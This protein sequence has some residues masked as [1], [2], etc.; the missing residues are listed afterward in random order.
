V[1]L[2]ARHVEAAS[3]STLCMGSALDIIK[4]GNPPRAAFLD[5]PLGHTTGKPHQPELQREILVQALEGFTSMT[6]PGSVKILPFRWSEEDEWKHTAMMDGDSRTPRN[7]IPQY[8][9]EE[10]RRRAEENNPEACLVCEISA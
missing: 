10:D 7:E 2:I 5:Y 1:G 6:V 4:A 3:I 9:T 8:Q